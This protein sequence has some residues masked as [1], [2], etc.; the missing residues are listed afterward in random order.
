MRNSSRFVVLALIVPATLASHVV[1]G[2]CS[3]INSFDPVRDAE[4]SEQGAGGSSGTAG[5]GGASGSGGTAGAGGTAGTAGTGG[6]HST[7]VCGAGTFD[8]DGDPGTPCV[9]FTNCVPGQA[10]ASLGNPTED[11]TCSGC[12]SGTFTETNNALRCASWKTCAAGTRVTN[13]PSASEDR[14]CE[15]CGEGTTTAGA[16]QAVCVPVA[17]CPAGT[18]QTAPGAGT[19][20][21]V[22]ESC[23][24]GTYCAGD[25]APKL[26]CAAGSWDHDAS[27]ATTCAAKTDCTAGQSVAGEGSATENRSCTGC[28][29]G[30][31]S[32]QQ[33][34]S[35]C[36]AWTNC[37]PGTHVTNTPSTMTDRSCEACTVGTYTTGSNEA[38]CQPQNACPAGTVQT[39]AGTGT[40]PPVC[41]SCEAGSYCAGGTAAR[42]LCGTG[43]WDHDGS[44]A[45]TCTS[46]TACVA[47]EWVANEGSTTTNRSCV[48]CGSGA[49]STQQ[50]APS[51]ASW[52]DCTAGT[53][54]AN[55]P[56]QTADRV[57]A[58]CGASSYS[59]TS[60]AASCATWKDCQAGTYVSKAGTATT[61]RTC[62]TCDSGKYT[63]EPNAAACLPW[64]CTPDQP[65]C[66][67][68]TATSCNAVGSGYATS[69]TACGSDV[70]VAGVCERPSCAGLGASCGP[71]RD[72]SCCASSLVPGGTYNR[73]N[74]A[75]YPA[76][77]SGFFLDTYE[78]TVGRFRRF[79]AAYTQGMIAAGAGKNPN[80][81]ADAGWDKAWDASLPADATALQS[82]V[83]CEA[84]YQTWTAS[85]G[86][87]ENKP[88]NCLS[89]YEAE[90]FCIWDGGRLPTEAEWNYAAAGGSDQRK[91]PWGFAEPGADAKLAV[92]GCYYSGD[93]SCFAADIAPVGSAAAG[94]GRW[95]QADLAGN[96]WEWV[97]DGSGDYPSPCLDCAN[98][99]APTYR[100][101]RGG[102]FVNDVL[103]QSS[104]SRSNSKQSNHPHYIGARCARSAP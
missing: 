39:A 78:I 73:S 95:G 22:C 28:G 18:L 81:A 51:C 45:T 60:N 38:T 23:E 32:T 44:A 93:S 46:K 48:A 102:S 100:G 2:G 84:T 33:N 14:D 26:S 86:V 82:I 87:N 19:K 50:N 41:E 34:A 17:A 29:S 70:C 12:E 64:F 57:C 55:T 59:T 36:A 66:D 54:V 83:Q 88:M 69:G 96:M 42:V 24:A 77:V 3:V 7:G 9:A 56:S 99:N 43:T 76:T 49:F 30:S 37:Q 13:E 35:S 40:A 90:A 63:T 25:Q 101:I 79:V 67:G 15:E 27:S 61:E 52:K 62:A 47:G 11:R 72:R 74:D 97:Q 80:N 1:L 89:W 20:P 53:Y 98:S 58:T 85:A 104:S 75:R 5:A 16:N 4:P 21:P 92:Y 10:V 103:D 91:Y 65:A 71:G 6:T 94:N 68:N 31:F 8:D